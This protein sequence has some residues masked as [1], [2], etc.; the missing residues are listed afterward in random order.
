[1]ARGLR[2]KPRAV[3]HC[4]ALRIGG[5]KIKPTDAREG[6]RPGAHGAGLQRHVEIAVAQS[7]IAKHAGSLANGQYFR[8]S[9]GIAVANGAI[10]GAGDNFAGA[11]N[12][13]ANR[14]LATRGRG[15][16]LGESP[17]HWSSIRRRFRHLQLNLPTPRAVCY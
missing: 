3:L 10:A 14:S 4:A 17:R 8:M 2:E 1:M 7:F 12:G 5:A 16:R 6:Y 13:C 9:G 15:A 11:G